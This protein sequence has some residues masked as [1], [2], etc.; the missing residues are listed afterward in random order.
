MT[1]PRDAASLILINSDRKRLLW[2]HRNPELSFLGGFHSFTGGKLEEDDRK[3]DVRN[4]PDG[5]MR[6]LKA[7]AVRETF[8]ECGVLVVR[9]GDKLTK[10]QFPLLHDDLVS[11]REKF[12]EILEHWGLWI[13][14]RDLHYAGFWTTP[15]FSPVRFKTRFFLAECPDKLDPYAATEELGNFEFLEPSEALRRWSRS[16]VLIAPPVSFPIRE[17]AE[18]ATEEIDIAATASALKEFSFKHSGH[19]DHIELNSHLICIPL[20]TKTLPPATH[21]NCFIVGKKRYVVIDAASREAEEQEKLFALI[22]DLQSA[23]GKCEAI[24]ISHLHRDH[25]GGE[26]NLKRYLK[27]RYRE[28]VPILAHDETIVAIGNETEINGR[29]QE[30]DSYD[31]QD[32]NGTE[33]RLEVIHSPGHA[34]GHLCFYD[35]EYGFLLTSDNVLSH[36]SVLINPP[37]GNMNDYLE[38]LERLRDLTGLRFLCG[39]HGPAVYNAKDKIEEYIGHRLER[40]EQVRRALESGLTTP[41]VIAPVIYDGLDPKLLPLAERSVAAHLERLQSDKI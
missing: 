29:L 26:V 16:K 22:D 9:N 21:T 10:G 11:G 41:E 36:G 31:L 25:F 5:E 17:M 39:S 6:A 14:G 27:D 24:I 32:A 15:E 23:G 8:E 38:S 33:F 20:R 3:C 28:E 30:G 19:V 34:R 1:E 37:E 2:G 7:C 35:P 40:E 13:D 18:T 4:E 12:S